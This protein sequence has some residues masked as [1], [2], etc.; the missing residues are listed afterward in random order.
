M[1]AGL[2]EAMKV[3]GWSEAHYVDMMP[4]NPLGPVCTAATIHFAAAVPNFAWLETRVARR[5]NHGF[6]NAEFFPVQ[7]RLNGADY[8]VGDLP[9]LGVEV[10]EAVVQEQSFKF[11]GSAAPGAATVQSQLVGHQTEESIM[12]HT[13]DITRPPKELID[14]LKEIGAATVAGTL[15]HMGFRNPHMVGPVAQN[16]GKSIV[17]P[18]LTLQFMPQRPDL[19]TEGEYADPETQLHR[20]VLYHAQEGDVVVVDARGDMSS[21]V[22]GDMMSTYFKGRGGAG[23]VIDGCMRDRP[24]VEKLDLPLWL[25][26]WTPNYH[27]QTSI[28]PNAVNVPIACGGVTVIPGDII[29]A[30]D[31]G[32][33]VL[34]VAMA[35]KVIEESQKH[36]D[37][38]EFSRVKLM[39]GAPLQRYYPLHDDARG[40]Y[41]EWRKINRLENPS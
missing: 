17:G 12:T 23:I 13:P 36:H 11:L 29:V 39:E 27:V 28:Y 14:A 30:D 6:D 5:L 40:E 1:S 21:G 15:G 31:D 8:P 16:H 18:A 24:N 34:P 22:F 38:E 25:R 41:E 19:F 2:T 9:G 3:A 26:G 20:H 35:A 37:W 4:H 10:N 32:V 33:V 7:P